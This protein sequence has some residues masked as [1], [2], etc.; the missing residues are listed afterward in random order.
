[1]KKNILYIINPISGGK[2]KLNFPLIA[3][4]FMDKSRYSAKYLFSN[5]VGHAHQLALEHLQSEIDIIVAVGGDGTINEIASALLNSEKAMGIIPCGSGNGLARALKIP[6]SHESAVKR[7]NNFRFSKIDSGT[8]NGKSFF[9]MAGIGFDAHIS[10]RFADDLTRGLKGYVKTTFTEIGQYTSQNYKIKIDGKDYEREA[11][12]ISIANSSQFGNNAHVSPFASV[13][14]GLL[15]VC[16]IKPFPMYHLPVMG[17]HMFSKT[18]HKS[19]YV[20]II[21]GKNIEILREEDGAIH[22]DGE[23]QLMGKQLDIKIIPLSLTLLT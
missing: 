11:F 13:T 16:V 17:Y 12:M 21:Q 6:L 19:K 14:D 9:N 7:L 1:M 2:S 15:D 18:A 8:F 5:A 10:K 20:E 22:L 4:R 23:P 3:D